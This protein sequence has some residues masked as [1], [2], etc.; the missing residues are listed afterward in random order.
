MDPITQGLLGAVTAQ[1]GFRQRIGRDATLVATAAAVLPDLD[2]L[3]APILSLTGAE[4]DGMAGL[5]FHRGWS[6]SLLMAPFLSLPVALIW[7]WFRRRR[8][9]GPATAG[10]GPISVEHGDAET[11]REPAFWLLYLCVFVAVSTHPLLDWCTSY[12]TQLLAPLTNRRFALDAVPIVDLIYTP[13]LVATLI[14]CYLAR[15]VRPR[16]WKR[17]SLVIG[18]TGFGLSV[19]YL[20]AGLAMHDWAVGKADQAARA[21]GQ[22]ALRTNAFPAMGSIFLWRTVVETENGWV[23]MRAHFFSRTP[24]QQWANQR[25][26]RVDNVWIDKA[27]SVGEAETYIWFTNGCVRAQYSLEDGHHVVELHDMR[28]GWPLDSV[29]SFWPVTVVFD[30]EGKLLRVGRERHI[31]SEGR[32]RFVSRLW[33]DLWNP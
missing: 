26:E 9:S 21:R 8:R 4:L 33:S 16:R 2:V 15:K 20:V 5:R 27:R 6:H 10:D 32:R 3:I 11:G 18:W 28:Y 23:A 24:V 25:A 17:V 14:A 31:R 29:E 30:G 1:L 13:L 19:G 12:G 22:T 7:W